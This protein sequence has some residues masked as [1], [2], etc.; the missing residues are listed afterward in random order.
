MTGQKNNAT[1]TETHRHINVNQPM[2]KLTNN[3]DADTS[4]HDPNPAIAEKHSSTD[5][6]QNV[7]L[8]HDNKALTVITWLRSVTRTH[9]HT[10]THAHPVTALGPSGHPYAL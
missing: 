3:T 2:F 10:R 7:S 4:C 1:H 6:K 5:D 9:T 8:L